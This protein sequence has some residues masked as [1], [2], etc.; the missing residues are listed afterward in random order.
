MFRRMFVLNRDGQISVRLDDT[1]RALIKQVAEELRE[2]LL[3]ED[4]ELTRRLYP[5]AY[6]DDDE[7]EDDYQEVV[8]DQLLM[9]RLDGIDQLQ[10]TIDDE[11]ISVDTA[12]AWMNTINQI[13]LV[14]GTKLDVG[15]EQVEIDQDDPE[16][17]SHVIYQVLSHILEE[18]TSARISAL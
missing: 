14:L 12:D 13:R 7:A 2:V 3:V 6:P 17:T 11:E 10:A 16:A 5:T 4:P 1:M 18:L 9:Q 15:E 8:H